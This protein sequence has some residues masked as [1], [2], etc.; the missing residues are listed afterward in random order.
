M[1]ESRLNEEEENDD[2]VEE[3]P[4]AEVEVEAEDVVDETRNVCNRL[5]N[6]RTHSI[7]LP[8]LLLLPARRS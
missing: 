5:I 7:L 1:P 3:E 8:L 2:E 4:E 6:G